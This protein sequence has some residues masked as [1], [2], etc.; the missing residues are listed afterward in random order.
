MP[1]WQLFVPDGAYSP[2]DKIA[3]AEAITKIYTDG[4]GLPRFYV[5]VVFHDVPKHSFLIGGEPREDFVR[6]SIDHIARRFDELPER[7]ELPPNA[8]LGQLWRDVCV[9]VLEP[10]VAARGFDWELHTDETP[11]EY[12]YIQGLIP[13]PAWSEQE[14]SWADQNKAT[15]YEEVSA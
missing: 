2:E 13:P 4:A 3:L 7:L 8:D 1:M 11:V 14:K 10:Y 12:W 5:S 15:P 6:I 9:A